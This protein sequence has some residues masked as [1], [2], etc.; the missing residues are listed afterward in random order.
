MAQEVE[1]FEPSEDEVASARKA[2]GTGPVEIPIE[3]GAFGPGL[4]DEL[5]ELFERF[6]G[7]SEVILR[8]TTRDG[9]RKL[10]FGDGYRVKPSAALTAELDALLGTSA[11]AA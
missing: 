5:K 3:A 10:R 4:I 1:H 9:S 8:M 2:R 7:E 6:P 11:R